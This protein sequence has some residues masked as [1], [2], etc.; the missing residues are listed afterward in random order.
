MSREHWSYIRFNDCDMG[1]VFRN[2]NGANS[3]SYEDTSGV[4]FLN[5]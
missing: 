5:L 3:A 4:L 1:G 2:Q